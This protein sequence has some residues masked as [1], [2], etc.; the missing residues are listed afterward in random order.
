[1]ANYR[2]ELVGGKTASFFDPADTEALK[3]RNQARFTALQDLVNYMK[4]DGVRVAVFDAPNHTKIRR[5]EVLDLLDKEGVGAKKMFIECICDDDKVSRLLN[6][7]THSV[8]FLC[9]KG[10]TKFW[11]LCLVFPISN[12][13]AY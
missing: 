2:R 4:K 12:R 5:Q 11:T 6:V 13:T 10:L 3:L 7:Q 1:M 8:P 9:Y